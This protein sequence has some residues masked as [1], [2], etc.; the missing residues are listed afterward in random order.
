[1]PVPGERLAGRPADR[2]EE[3]V[4]DAADMLLLNQ[5]SEALA[6]VPDGSVDMVIT[7]PPFADSVMYSELSDYFYVWLRQAL[8]DDY[9]NFATPQVDDAQAVHNP[10]RGRDGAF[11][12][13]VLGNV[14]AEARRR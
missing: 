3:L 1:M 5:S 6:L 7:D 12:T 10:G 11:Y 4:N 14:F 9:D 13:T 2:F 8:D